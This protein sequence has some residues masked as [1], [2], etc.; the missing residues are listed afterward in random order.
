MTSK[1]PIKEQIEDVRIAIDSIQQQITSADNYIS[2]HDYRHAAMP[3]RNLQEKW[4]LLTDSIMAFFNKFRKLNTPMQK[5]FK[6]STEPRF[7]TLLNVSAEEYV[8]EREIED[9]R[10]ASAILLTTIKSL[11][12]INAGA[13]ASLFAATV[14]YHDTSINTSYFL[15]PAVLFAFGLWGAI[16]SAIFAYRQQTG[17]FAYWRHSDPEYRI[18]AWKNEARVDFTMK[19]SIILFFLGLLVS[20]GLILKIIKLI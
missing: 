3:D 17:Y 14:K 5:D 16:F 12:V 11:F 19:F 2:E 15:L 18:D 7:L 1:Q 13:F 6:V 9:L 8:R 4:D 20:F 10:S